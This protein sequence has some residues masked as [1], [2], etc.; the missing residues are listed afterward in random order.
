M[1]R[2]VVM[3]AYREA[4]KDHAKTDAKLKE[5]ESTVCHL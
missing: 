3:K 5:C 1:D 4:L 2:A